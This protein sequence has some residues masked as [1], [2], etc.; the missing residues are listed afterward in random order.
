MAANRLGFPE[1]AP[2][3]ENHST[4][5]VCGWS[6]CT[7]TCRLGLS[8]WDVEIFESMFFDPSTEDCE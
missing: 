8:R 7:D 3:G 5:P 2:F 6:P 4:C 1:P